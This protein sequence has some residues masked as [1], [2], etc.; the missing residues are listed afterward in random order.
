L[1]CAILQFKP[2]R[3]PHRENCETRRKIYAILLLMRAIVPVIVL[4]ATLCPAQE[5]NPD[6]LLKTA[7][8]AQQSGDF[9]TAILDY[10]KILELRPDAFEAKVNLGAALVHVGQFDAAIDVYQSALVAAKEKN[11][12]LLNLGLAYYKKGDF[13]NARVQF[14][15][16]NKAKPND[17]RIA[18]LLGDTDIQVGRYATAV[19]LLMPL[20]AGNAQNPDFEYVLGSAL[21]KAGKRRD[22]VSRLEK[23]AELGKSADAYMLA[24]STLLDL[25]EFAQA[26]NDLEAALRLNPKLPGI[27]TLVGTARDKTGDAKEAEPVFREAVKINPDDFNANLY[28]GA[29]LY[30]RRELDEAKIY[31]E[32]AAQLNP[33]STMAGYELA[34][35]ESASGENEAAAQELGKV[36]AMDPT[37][38]EPHIELASLYYRLHRAVEGAKERQIVDRLAAE[39]QAQGPGK[40]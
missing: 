14:E 5:L 1:S 3:K 11:P 6:Q 19:T 21:I 35:Q 22:G 40:N 26:R 39:Q 29:I 12:I 25:S 32:K 31:L 2:G 8:S 20:E 24:G 38:L 15:I 27:Y 7:I 13:E 30:K 18:I 36:I 9:Q 34:M 37:W 4:L 28:L 16:L 10:R 33:A 23:S 17:V